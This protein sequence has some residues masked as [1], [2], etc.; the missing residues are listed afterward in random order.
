MILWEYGRSNW[1]GNLTTTYTYQTS[2]TAALHSLLSVGYPDGTHSHFV[3]D[4]YGRVN[5]TYADNGAEHAHPGD[6]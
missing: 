1:P 5:D 6:R 4:P 2:G 3:Y